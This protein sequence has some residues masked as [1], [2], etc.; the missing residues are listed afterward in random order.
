MRSRSLFLILTFYEKNGIVVFFM[1]LKRS[2]CKLQRGRVDFVL[3]C[4]MFPIELP[5]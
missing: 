4:R 1:V 2:R 3:K 5:L